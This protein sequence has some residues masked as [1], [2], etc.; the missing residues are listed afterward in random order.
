MARNCPTP[1]FTMND[2]EI[3]IPSDSLP[4]YEH[5]WTT[6]ASQRA[7]PRPATVYDG[8]SFTTG[9]ENDNSEPWYEAVIPWPFRHQR[10]TPSANNA[11]S[12]PGSDHQQDIYSFNTMNKTYGQKPCEDHYEIPVVET[13]MSIGQA[14]TTDTAVTMPGPNYVGPSHEDSSTHFDG[15]FNRRPIS[16]S[17][18]TVS[19]PGGLSDILSYDLGD[20]ASA[21]ASDAPSLS[22][23]YTLPSSNRNSLVSSIQLSPVA[24]PRMTPQSRTDLVR[25]LSRGRVTPNPRPSARSAPYNIGNKRWSTGCY[26]TTSQ[27]R[28]T[29]PFVYNPSQDVFDARQSTSS[30]HSSPTIQD[31]QVLCPVPLSYANPQAAQEQSFFSTPEPQQQYHAPMVLPTQA[32]APFHG[33]HADTGFYG[34]FPML[35]SNAEPHALHGHYMGSSD[36]PDM[37]AS[38]R[39]EHVPPPPEDMNP[40]DKDMIPREQQPR[41][42]GDLYTPRWVR[43]HGQKREGWC[44]ICRPGRWLVLKNSAYWYDKTFSHGISAPTGSPFPEPQQTRRVM[45]DPDAWEGFCSSCSDWVPLV[46]TKKQGIT[47]FRHWSKCG[48]N[49]DAVKRR[50]PVANGGGRT[51]PQPRAPMTPQMTPA[52][53]SGTDTPASAQVYRQGG[54]F[55]SAARPTPQQADEHRM[56][57][58]TS[59]PY[60][61]MP[62]M[63]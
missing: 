21:A 2:N 38:L 50:R 13:D 35:S 56:R 32:H 19:T 29:T 14:Y 61:T 49:K 54:L 60:E 52:T 28:T 22:S 7:V 46:G 33:F 16:G 43:G 62:N 25:T 58:P 41:F 17:S 55:P 45:G 48:K 30:R 24:S 9:E 31:Q 8:S 12:G 20:D 36:P 10:Q 37:Y 6:P 42:E 39:E 27:R 26:G 18:F 15:G 11:M 51:K 57:N 5:Q 34:H 23:D 4:L 3:P 63:I 1:V 44:G 59:S 47:W 53:V 40:E